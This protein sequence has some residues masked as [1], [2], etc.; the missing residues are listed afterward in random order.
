MNQQSL[1]LSSSSAVILRYALLSHRLPRSPAAYC[2]SKIF[3]TR[4]T[5]DAIL[6]DSGKTLKRYLCWVSTALLGT[7]GLV[8]D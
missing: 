8:R 1:R 2:P 4:K 6:A 7:N 5:S 3:A